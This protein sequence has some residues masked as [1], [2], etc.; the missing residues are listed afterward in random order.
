MARRARSG[1]I[2]APDHMPGGSSANFVSAPRTRNRSGSIVAH[3]GNTL[4]SLPSQAAG[5]MRRSRSGTVVPA[6]LAPALVVE[7]TASTGEAKQSSKDAST[8]PQDEDLEITL[9]NTTCDSKLVST[10]HDSAP[11]SPFLEDDGDDTLNFLD[12]PMV[13]SNP[14]DNY[15]P[16][17]SVDLVTD[18]NT[19]I[20]ARSL[21]SL[22]ARAKAAA[23]K[24][25]GLSKALAGKG[26]ARGKGMLTGPEA[27]AAALARA[28]ARAEENLIEDGSRDGENSSDDELLL[29]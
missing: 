19:V 22:R 2:M 4:A 20:N 1:S 13:F 6:P 18:A 11:R 14:K 17:H 28:R 21:N 23:S 26:G 10:T 8:P 27:G 3:V 9:A 29:K 12:G 5:I 24:A 7:R 16:A 25:K 15:S